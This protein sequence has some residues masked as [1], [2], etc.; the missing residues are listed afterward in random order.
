M[1]KKCPSCESKDVEYVATYGAPG[2][3]QEWKCNSCEEVLFFNRGILS[4]IEDM[5]PEDLVTN[6]EDER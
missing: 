4:L 6:I 5:Q 2:I 3:G 1:E